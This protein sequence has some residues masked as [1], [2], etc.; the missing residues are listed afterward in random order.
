MRRMIRYSNTGAVIGEVSPNDV[1][2]CI[3]RES[4]N[5]EHSIEITTIQ[6]L[7]KNE[8][9]VYQDARGYWHEYVI[10][11][12]DDEHSA[13]KTV[14]GTY[15]A[16]WSVQVD[17]MGINV[18][19]MPGTQAPVIA[20]EALT[21]ILNGQTRWSRGT[22]TNTNTGGA[23]M[24][25]MSAWKAM[26]VLV[27][28]WGG[29]VDTTITVSNSEVVGR[30]IDL[31]SQMG[32]QS[33]NRRYDFGADLS[34]VKRKFDDTPLY[35]RISPRGHGEQTDGGGYGRK[36]RITSVNDG[37]DYLEYAPMVD[38]AKVRDGSSW[39]YPTL[40]VENSDCE[41]PQELKDWALSV[42]EETCTP[43]ITY[44]VDAIQAALEGVSVMGV[45]LGDVVHIVDRYFGNGLRLEG[46]IKSITF[47]EV[48]ERETTV[49]IGYIGGT[50]SE[51]FASLEAAAIRAE[52]SVAALSNTL[53][54]SAYIN[55][56][57]DRI[58]TEINATGG[59]TYIIQGN[60]IRTYDAAVS[61]PLVGA[62]ASQVV[63][64][65]G[66]SIRI[67]N[68]KTAQ[69]AWEW[70]TVFTSGHIAADLVTAASIV[71]G[72]IGNANSG[73]Y[74]DLDNNLLRL[75]PT[76]IIDDTT[77][78]GLISKVNAPIGVNL[79]RNGDFSTGDLSY[80]TKANSSSVGT[81]ESDSTFAT[82]LSYEQLT[83]G[84]S[85]GIYTTAATS[86]THVAGKT[87]SIS[88]YAKADAANTL[89]VRV[90][91]STAS[92]NQY[93]NGVE[94]TTEW[95]RYQATITTTTSGVLR[96]FLNTAGIL[97]LANVMLVNGES[98]MEFFQDPRDVGGTI[99]QSIE[100]ATIIRPYSDGV[101][102]C[103]KG[104]TVGALVN[105]SGSFDVVNVTWSGSTPT[106]GTAYA[107]Y[108]G[109]ASVIGKASD[110]NIT[111][112]NT[113]ITMYTKA[114][115]LQYPMAKIGGST[116]E[117]T[118]GTRDED[119]TVGNYSMT[120]GTS[121]TASASG[122]IALGNNN[123]ASAQNAIALNGGTT[124]SGTSSLACG[125]STTASGTYSSSF[126]NHTTASASNS[127]AFG[128]YTTATGSNQ[129]VTGK[130]N[131]A[132]STHLMIVGS[133]TGD[134]SRGNAMYLT[135]AGAMWIVGSYTNAS[136]RRMKSH[137]SYLGEDAA[138]F[139][140]KL[141]PALYEKDGA[142][143]LGFYAQDVDAIDEW[144]TAT[145]AESDYDESLGFRPLSLEYSAL[146]APIV[147]YTQTLED[148][149]EKLE[150]ALK[151][152][153]ERV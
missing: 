87:Y 14:V 135:S 111:V 118:F 145:V 27:E 97:Y 67:A 56:L 69:G 142:K 15:Y 110:A 39:I 129:L 45:S 125:N 121:H 7:A 153:E 114:G 107:S 109:T 62:E 28:N 100:T 147:A 123:T 95:K 78:Q 128:L 18:S 33:A 11:G 113:D 105:S 91:T 64:I 31:Y 35:C 134:T 102:V 131:T 60:G 9:I 59:Y 106:A 148:R 53:S 2:E 152:S 126:G 138:E 88:F 72:S 73:N 54:T 83:A 66:G 98:S 51:R 140:R 65:K 57:L 30:A 149:I 77:L 34:S 137:I 10:I 139:V 25:D 70:K 117:F 112:S 127:V 74:W 133:G 144:D 93:L 90:G 89:T 86:F 92:A 119:S 23:S 124:A 52:E 26:S 84:S 47:D 82:H 122:S 146:I 132:N 104:N 40:I 94:L 96:F 99:G 116:R 136:D 22:V 43:N 85:Y 37:L 50:F 63:E 75:S 141:K 29:E 81:I 76:T 6:R 42:L 13:G 103:K 150:H 120:V 8:R 115:T 55:S 68:T 61:D 5:G 17:L 4:I 41:T 12:V 143:H 151:L 1:L 24:Y 46:R 49:T 48:N 21:S 58:N 80:W 3:R 36:I 38:A 130:Y 16:V 32:E 108:S 20:G 44:E 19:I 71:T 101:L 79:V